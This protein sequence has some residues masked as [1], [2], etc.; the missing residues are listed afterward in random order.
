MKR[1]F[2]RIRLRELRRAKRLKGIEFAKRIGCSNDHLSRIENGGT[3]PS[4]KLVERMAKVLRVPAESL[5]VAEA[6]AGALS[7]RSREENELLG[8][9]RRLSPQQADYVVALALSLADGGSLD[10]A[11]AAAQGYMAVQESRRASAA[12]AGKPARRGGTDGRQ[13]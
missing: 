12:Q 10:A 4:R 6:M 8:A 2:D 5:Y 9:F 7:T 3:S 11:A 1:A 13:A